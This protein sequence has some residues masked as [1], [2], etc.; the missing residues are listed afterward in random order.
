MAI[1]HFKISQHSGTITRN[2]A[3]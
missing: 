3:I 1:K 2:V